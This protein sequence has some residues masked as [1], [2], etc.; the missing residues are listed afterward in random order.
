MIRFISEKC[1]NCG[2]NE[3]DS[4]LKCNY[5]GSQL[6]KE[7]EEL[8]IT[9][10]GSQCP[11]CHTD[12]REDNDFCRQCGEKLQKKCPFCLNMH[13]ANTVFCPKSGYNIKEMEEKRKVAKE[14]KRE[15]KKSKKPRLDVGSIL[16]KTIE[17]EKKSQ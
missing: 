5:C 7:K 2:A 17:E 14:K 3:I 8:I 13:P 11:K 15:G 1:P 6:K 4:N 10:T 9:A 12:N 16:K